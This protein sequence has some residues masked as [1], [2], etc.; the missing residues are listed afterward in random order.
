MEPDDLVGDP[1]LAIGFGR[2]ILDDLDGL[3]ERAEGFVSDK[4]S[5]VS[6]IVDW[7]ETNCHV[8]ERQAEVLCDVRAKVDRWIE[9]T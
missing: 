2:E 4:E 3:P 8:T 5:I 7:I 9:R 6:G 1:D